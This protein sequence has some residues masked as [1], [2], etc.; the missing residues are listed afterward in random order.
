MLTSQ[1]EKCKQTNN[2]DEH[3]QI[4]IQHLVVRKV[5]DKNNLYKHKDEEYM[6]K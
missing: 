1:P 4:K 3:M 6:C 2:N 5:T